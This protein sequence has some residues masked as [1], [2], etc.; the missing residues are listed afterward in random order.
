MDA[1]DID[2]VKV[3]DEFTGEKLDKVKIGFFI[4][5]LIVKNLPKAEK[6]F[7]ELIMAYKDCSQKE[8][9]D[10]D[11][12]DTIKEIMTDGDVKRFLF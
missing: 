5:E 7:Y 10:C 8:A 9:E 2:L 6:E 12:I 1:A 4:V 3:K 11:I